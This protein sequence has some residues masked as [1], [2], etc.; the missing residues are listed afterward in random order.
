VYIKSK[1]NDLYIG[2]E[3]DPLRGV[4]LIVGK[5]NIAKV[6][7]IRQDPGHPLNYVYGHYSEFVSTPKFDFI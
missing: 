2:F 5:R 7:N 6:W 3:G 4:K 1:E